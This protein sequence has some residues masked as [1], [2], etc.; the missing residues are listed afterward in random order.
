M[1]FSFFELRFFLCELGLESG[2]KGIFFFYRSIFF[3]NFRL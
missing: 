1:L 3:S 2:D